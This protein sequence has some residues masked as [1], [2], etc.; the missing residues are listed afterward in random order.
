MKDIKL[1]ACSGAEYNGELARQVAIEL[2][3]NSS[4]AD[5]TSMFCLTIFLRNILLN[6]E[7]II[8]ITKDQLSSSFIVVVDG[9]TGLCALKIL[10]HLGI[11]ADLIVNVQQLVPKP[12]INFSD[13]ESFKNRPRMHNVKKEDVEKVS[14]HIIKRLKEMKAI[15]E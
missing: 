1:I 8:K 2:S 12:K 15:E 11:K 6:E 10:K 3:E 9:C 13:I 5:T 14:N 7:Q 4:I